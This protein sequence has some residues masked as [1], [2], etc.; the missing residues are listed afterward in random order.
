MAPFV[1]SCLVRKSLLRHRLTQRAVRS[2]LFFFAS[3]ESFSGVQGPHRRVCASF[4][5]VHVEWDKLRATGD[6]C[7]NAAFLPS[8][9][10]PTRCLQSAR[11]RA[12][13]LMVHFLPGAFSNHVPETTLSSSSPRAL[14]L[15][16]PRAMAPRFE[17]QSVG[18]GA[19]RTHSLLEDG[20]G[21]QP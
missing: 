2:L 20:E 17:R 16:P 6:S 10:A 13:T 3:G 5:V 14:L 19:C 4:G 18:H 9:W 15:P 12:G 1:K 7:P 11:R 21:L 8:S